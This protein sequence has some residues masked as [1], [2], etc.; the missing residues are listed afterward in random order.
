MGKFYTTDDLIKMGQLG[1]Y[2]N[3]SLVVT[4]ALIRLKQLELEN[5][6]LKSILESYQKIDGIKESYENGEIGLTDLE[7]T[8]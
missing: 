8:Y 2:G 7:N 4:R 3:Y 5:K 6:E 1:N